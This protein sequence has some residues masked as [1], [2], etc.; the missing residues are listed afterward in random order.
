VG[1]VV[2]LAAAVALGRFVESLLFGV[3]RTD[4]L[5]MIVSAAIVAAVSAAAACLPARRAASADPVAALRRE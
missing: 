2:G 5:T 3:E 1:I 4:P